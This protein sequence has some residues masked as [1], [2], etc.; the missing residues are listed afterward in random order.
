MLLSSSGKSAQGGSD[1]VHLGHVSIPLTT[2]SV[3]QM[4]SSDGLGKDHTHTGSQR[5]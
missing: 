3:H 4:V 5:G 2:H 1:W